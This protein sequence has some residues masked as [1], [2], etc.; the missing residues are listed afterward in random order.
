[1]KRIVPFLLGL[2]FVGGFSFKGIAEEEYPTKRPAAVA[3]KSGGEAIHVTDQAFL[4][5]RVENL[6]RRLTQLEGDLR[7]MEERTR[8][9]D[10]RINDLRNKS[11]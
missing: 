1:M 6:E 11:T 8:S 2:V 3:Q 5:N 10:R 4:R 7:F 9:L